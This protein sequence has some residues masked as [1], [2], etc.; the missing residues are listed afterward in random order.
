[1]VRRNGELWQQGAL[2]FVV[3]GFCLRSIVIV[4]VI[5]LAHTYRCEAD[6]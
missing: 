4:T 6:G 5:T 2:Y 1:V 3:E